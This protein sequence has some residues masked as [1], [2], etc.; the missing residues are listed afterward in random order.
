[1]IIETDL[2]VCVQ[3]RGA[4]DKLTRMEQINRNR[5]VLGVE[6]AYSV[7]ARESIL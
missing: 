4:I 1:V 5:L 3:D 6:I 2:P 7:P